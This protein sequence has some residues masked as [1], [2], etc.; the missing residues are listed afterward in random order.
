MNTNCNHKSWDVPVDFARRMKV[1]CI[2][3]GMSG[4]LCGIRFKQRIPNLDLVIYEKNSEVG[5]VWLENR[6]P[7]VTCGKRDSG[8][9]IDALSLTATPGVIRCAVSFQYTFENNP[10]WSHFFSPGPEIGRYFQSVAEKYGMKSL[11]KFHHVFKSA[12]WLEEEAQWEVTLVNMTDGTEFKD[13]CNVFVKATGNLNNWMWPKIDG[14]HTFRGPLIHSANWDES[15]DPKGKRVAVVGYG[16][17]A[18]QLVPAILPEVQHMDHYVRG[19][20]WI[21]PAGYVAADPRKATSD[22]HNFPFPPEEQERFEKYPVEYLNYRH[23]V[24]NFVNKFQLVHWVGSDMNRSFSKATE[25]SMLRRLATRP[26]IFDALKPTYPVLCRRV[27]PGPRY[28]EALTEPN[29]N[30]IPQGIRKVTETGIVDDIGVYREVDAIICATGFDTSLSLK[31]TPIFGRGGVSL[32]DLWEEEPGAYMSMSPPEMPNC[33]FFVGPNGAPGAGS[34]IQMSEVTCEYMIKCILKLQRENLKYMVPKISAVKAFMKQVDRYFEKT[35]F[36]FTCNNW[37]KRTSN[38]RMLGYWPGSAVHQR[39]TLMH[40]RFEDFEYVSND[41]NEGDSLAWMGNGMIMAQEM[42]TS[43]TGYLDLVDKPPVIGKPAVSLPRNDHEDVRACIIEDPSTK[44]QYPRGYVEALEERVARLEASLSVEDG[45]FDS[46][47]HDFNRPHKHTQQ[48]QEVPVSIVASIDA[49]AQDSLQNESAN[50]NV[51]TMNEL[52]EGPSVLDL[53][54][55]RA[56]GGEPHYF[57]SSSAFSFTKLFTARLRG[58]QYPF[59]H[60]P[61]YTEYEGAV[62]TACENGLTPDPLKAFFVFMVTAVGALAVP[63]AGAPLPE[64]L[65][66]AAEDLFEHV[67]QLNSLETIQ[68]LL[69]CAMYSLRSP[70]GVSIWT[71]SGLAVRQCVELGLHRDIPWS[72]VESNTLKT[73]V[74]RRVFWCSYN[75]DRACAVTLGRPVSITDE[76][77]DVA[78]FLDI[79]DENITPTGFLAQARTSNLEPATVVSSA[80]HTIRLRRIWARMQRTIYRETHSVAPHRNSS[81]TQKFKDELRAWM[82]AAPEQLVEGCAANNA[83]G[84][85]EWYKLMYYHSILLLHRRRLVVR[86]RSSHDQSRWAAPEC[87][88]ASV[89]LDCA[90]SSQAICEL[91]RTLY[92][93][94][95]LNDTWGALHVLFLAGLTYVH[96]LWNSPETR[97]TIRRD[98]VS[99]TCTSCMIV[100]AVMSERWDAVAPYRDTFEALSNATQAMLVDL[101][102]ASCMPSGP[103]LSSLQADQVSNYF[104]GM[105][106]IGMCSSVEQLLMDMITVEY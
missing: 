25:D 4:I 44:R 43:T 1:I 85:P 49:N 71:L 84:S 20:A 70:I 101:E 31:E 14:L 37:A 45:D 11:V 78:L 103:V 39:T 86:Q 8:M 73:E 69:C 23:Q 92:L 88:D 32:D 5:G 67:L 90:S 76:D 34:T 64:S 40:P 56:A 52:S 30:F 58:A 42:N 59:L 50:N 57:G 83:F 35:T 16:A 19:Q 27:S 26:E 22:I 28:L 89:Y 61:T 82:D 91:Y 12:R 62:M 80:L 6:Y 106:D 68:A 63:F 48:P 105:A 3:A 65:Y 95:R 10:N 13:Y 38:G 51:E 55:L 87:D 47:D 7:G 99:S 79:D 102:T 18:V 77:I 21:S 96:C 98:I 100:L 81:S 72:K 75:L 9:P 29:L 15:F 17:T 60:R 33:F 74:R 36:A 41:E 24:E 46:I 97:N 94:Q 104:A 66:T 2:G 54:C 53:L 93:S